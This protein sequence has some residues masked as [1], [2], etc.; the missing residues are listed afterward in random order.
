MNPCLQQFGTWST[1]FI[2]SFGRYQPKSATVFNVINPSQPSQFCDNLGTIHSRVSCTLKKREEV[3]LLKPP[4]PFNC[5]QNATYRRSIN[6]QDDY[7]REGQ[8]ASWIICIVCSSLQLKFFDQKISSAGICFQL[9]KSG[10]LVLYG[11]RFPRGHKS[12]MMLENGAA[13]V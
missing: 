5:P 4:W 9:S 11:S 3:K 12:A 10:Q 2:N 7:D 13:L 1:Q 8:A 6:I